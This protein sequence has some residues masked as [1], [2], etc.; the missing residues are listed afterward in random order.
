MAQMQALDTTDRAEAVRLAPWA[1][2]VV[3]TSIGYLAFETL[4]AYQH[5]MRR[6]NF[7]AV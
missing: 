5:W 4:G 2:Y 7:R 1:Q 6:R 3:A